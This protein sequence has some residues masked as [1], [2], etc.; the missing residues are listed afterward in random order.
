MMTLNTGIGRIMTDEIACSGEPRRTPLGGLTL[1]EGGRAQGEVRTAP[2]ARD[3]LDEAGTF[4]GNLLALLQRTVG[5]YRM[6]DASKG[7]ET[8]YSLVRGLELF[9]QILG[10]VETHLGIDF[11]AT[12]HRGEPLDLAVVRLNTVFMEVVR[13]QENRDQVFLA[14]VLAYEL[15]PLLEHWQ[16][17]FSSL[18]EGISAGSASGR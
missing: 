12:S 18:Q 14:D 11:A 2:V 5:L 3:V 9:T 10:V 15:A 6:G 4:T 1:V 8:F 7:G 16:E 17:L 13:A